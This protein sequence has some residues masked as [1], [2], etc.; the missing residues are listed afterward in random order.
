MLSAFFH[1]CRM[2]M[3]HLKPTTS[4]K[5]GGKIKKLVE[6]LYPEEMKYLFNETE[7]TMM[8]LAE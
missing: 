8:A 7:T 5:I 6:K 2:E 3:V 1:K 4:D